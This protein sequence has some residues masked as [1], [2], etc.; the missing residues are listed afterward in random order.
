[1]LNTGGIFL[2]IPVVYSRGISDTAVD[3]ESK[4]LWHMELPIQSCLIALKLQMRQATA[5]L[6]RGGV[7]F[8][9]MAYL[10]TLSLNG[11]IG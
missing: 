11:V 9:P 5:V 8:L 4:N 1:M 10:R 7:C 3:R 2:L 6:P